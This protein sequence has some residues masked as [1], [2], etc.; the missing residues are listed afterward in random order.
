MA[1]FAKSLIGDTVLYIVSLN[2]K[3]KVVRAINIES[4]SLKIQ[5]IPLYEVDDKKPRYREIFFSFRKKRFYKSKKLTIK[6][7]RK[8]KKELEHLKP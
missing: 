1:E 8:I 4:K 5:K 3:K 6:R 7:Y 2:K